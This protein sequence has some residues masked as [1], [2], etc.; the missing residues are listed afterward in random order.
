MQNPVIRFL[1]TA[2]AAGAALAIQVFVAPKHPVEAAGL[3]TALAGLC[4]QY[5]VS[6]MR[7]VQPEKPAA[8]EDAK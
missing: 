4:T 7:P 3:L 2:A 5:G 6:F 1:E 8:T